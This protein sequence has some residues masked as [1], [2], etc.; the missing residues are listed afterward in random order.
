[1]TALEARE[2]FDALIASASPALRPVCEALRERI[3][4]LHKGFAEVVWP[5]LNMASYGVGP[6]KATEHYAYIMVHASHVN[7][8][9]Y[10]GATLPDPSGVLQGSGKKLRH[11]K[12]ADVAATQA[13]AITALLRAG[14][15][16]RMS[17]HH[18]A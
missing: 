2:S 4:A 5:R 9:F 14:I 1:M 16:D 12:L 11:I 15:A 6:R 10:H 3:A 13:P 8:G 18:E 17:R 7:L